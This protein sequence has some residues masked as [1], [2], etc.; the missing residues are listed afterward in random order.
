MVTHLN[1][2]NNCSF[3]FTVKI[4]LRF[5][6]NNPP[7][8]SEPSSMS[9]RNGGQRSVDVE[10]GYFACKFKQNCNKYNS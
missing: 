3:H 8:V 2:E 1:S 9:T 4:L 6:I 5:C 10:Y 7:V